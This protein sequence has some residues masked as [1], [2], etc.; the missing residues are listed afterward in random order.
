MSATGF[1]SSTIS[2][3]SPLRYRIFRAMW[4]AITASNIGTWMN[5]VGVTWMMAN[6][7]ASNLLVALI[8]TATTLPFLLFS[9]PSGT[10]ADLFNRR[11]MLLVLHV[12]MLLSATALTLLTF[13]GLTT[14]WWLLALTF[15]L[16]TGNAMMRPAFS[17]CIPAFVPKN[18]LP[19]AITLNSLSTNAS[20]AIG[21][22]LGGLIIAMTGPYVVFALNALSFIVILTILYLRFP[23]TLGHESRLPAENFLRAL[24]GGIDY[25]LHDR[26]F[27]VVLARC[28]AFFV[29]ASAF[30]SLMPALL[31]REFSA[32]AESYGALM[33]LTGIG[34]V[35]GAMVMP[36]LYARWSRNA[37]FGITTVLYGLGLLAL[38]AAQS[39]FVAGAIAVVMGLAW[40][41]GFSSLIVACQLTVPDWVR[42]RAL[43]IV[44]LSYGAS[45]TPSSAFWGYLADKVGISTGLAVA[46]AGT[47]ATLL[48]SAWLPLSS[49][50]RD[51]TRAEI[52]AA[53]GPHNIDRNAGL[54]TLSRTYRVAEE[55]REAF[56]TAMQQIRAL[57]K[58]NGAHS[59][60]LAEDEPGVFTEVVTV[61]SGLDYLR[62]LE[63]VTA[64]DDRLMRQA[65]ALSVAA[66]QP[67]IS[68]SD[69][70][71]PH[72]QPAGL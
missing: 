4:I 39:L 70:R 11:R 65:I 68:Q 13:Q 54:V 29:F 34:A 20:K 45:A 22:A 32:S 41:T 61:Q 17:A 2:V 23:H 59:W 40:I 6:L 42:A 14:E 56:H 37:L 24:K 31:I 63:R 18:E 52:P 25:T 60:Q 1:S 50:D 33:A 35:S 27:L 5:E 47:L 64:D 9:Y 53:I 49:R 48:L 26:E 7:S 30:W 72:K 10:L 3:W 46:G 15:A 19:Q 16:A 67:I 12:W 8:Q 62:Q 66:N 71:A 69:N 38:A 43:A 58:R 57:C 44:M 55:N 51:H 21:P 28:V 36:R